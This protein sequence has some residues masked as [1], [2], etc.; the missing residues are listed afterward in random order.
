MS[1]RPSQQGFTLIETIAGVAVFSILIVGIL[2]AY[3]ALATSVKVAREKTVLSSLAANYLE[4][5]RN[6]PYSEVGTINGN[7][8]GTLADASNPMSVNIESA[9]YEIYYEVTYVDDS[10]D[11]TILLGTDTAPNDYKQIKLSIRKL[12]TDTTTNFL[13]TIAP[14]GLEGLSNAGALLIRVIDANGQPLEGAN[15][16]IENTALNPDIILDRQTDSA[17]QVIE[18]ALPES[19]NGYRIV[20]TK[21][22]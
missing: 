11:G 13:T 6:L 9:L 3:S 20:V 7:P 14:K 21:N 17:G 12:A 10:A 5:V 22:G 1:L 18:V 4:V 15:V 16:H 2:S 8:S 19:V